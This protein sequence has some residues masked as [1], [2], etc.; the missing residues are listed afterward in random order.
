MINDKLRKYLNDEGFDCIIL[1]EPSFDNSITG[2]STDGRLVYDFDKMVHEC[3][4]D[5]EL[6]HDAAIEFIS[7]NTLRALPYMGE[8]APIVVNRFEGV[9]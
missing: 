9:E 7:Y 6:D 8:K 5:T 2:F 1:D 3:I 4:T